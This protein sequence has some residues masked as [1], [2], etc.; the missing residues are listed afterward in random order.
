MKK[1]LEEFWYGN[2]HPFEQIVPPPPTLS[3]Q[4]MNARNILF[5]SLSDAQM[6]YF[7][8][9]ESVFDILNME[10]T[11]NAFSLGFQLGAKFMAAIEDS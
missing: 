5:D 6:E 1:V 10:S 4:A 11:K 8:A 2:I 9:Y 3:K 7:E